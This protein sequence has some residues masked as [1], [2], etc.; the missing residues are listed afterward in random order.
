MA[1]IKVNAKRLRRELAIRGWDETDLA[2][3]ADLSVA[4]VSHMLHGRPVWNRSLRQIAMALS[5]Y[6]PMA[7]AAE[8]LEDD[9]GGM[10]ESG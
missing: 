5:R 7:G 3:H 4:T 9:D 1:S 6:P 10:A 2:R 8:L